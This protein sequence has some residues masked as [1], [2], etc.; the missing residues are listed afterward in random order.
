[1]PHAIK[2]RLASPPSDSYMSAK[3]LTDKASA[4]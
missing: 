3:S 2:L 1:L 4:E